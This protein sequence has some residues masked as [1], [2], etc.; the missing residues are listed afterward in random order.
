MKKIDAKTQSLPWWKKPVSSLKGIGPKKAIEFEGL[1][2]V[3]IGDLLNH[4]PR[5]GCYLDY[6][7][8]KTIRE[9]TLDGSMQ[10]FRGQI[11]R[12]IKRRSARN[13]R[14][15]S[16]VVSDGTAFAEIFLFGAQVYAVRYLENGD[17][18]LVIGKVGPGRTAKAVTQAV[19]S[20]VKD[21]HPEAPGILP[22]YAL[23]GSLTQKNVRSAVR[24]ALLLAKHHLP[25]CLPDWI[26]RKKG[27][28]SRYEALEAIHFPP[29]LEKMEEAR[30][31]FIF[32]ELFFIQCGLL[33]HRANIK[34]RSLGIKM[35]HC[36][37][38]WQSVLDHLGF[39]LTESQKKAWQEINDDMESPE[40]M[41]RLLQ[42]DVGSGKT[43]VAMLALAKAAEN[44]Y[45]GCL[46]APT[47]I[48]AEQHYKEMQKVLEPL[49]IH[50]AL[51]TGSLGQAARREVLEGLADGTI[52][53]VVGTYALIQDAVTFHS[54][55][56]AI[57]DE[58]HRFGV[59]QRS[60][61]SGKSSYT[62]H[63]L[64]MTATPIPR[65]LAL[66]VYG[67]LDVSLMKGLPPGRKPIKTLCYTDEKRADVYA[68]LIHQVKEGHQ[69]YIVAPLIEGSDTV[70]AKSATDL[71]EELTQ[72]FLK[73]IPCG[74]LHGRL[75]AEEKDA[76]MADFV[77]GKTKVLIATTVIEVGVNVPN[78]TL[79]IIEG[80]DRFGLAQMHQLRGRVGRG[81]SQSYCVLLTGSNQPQTLERL[82]IMRSCSDGFLLAEKD[83][84]LRGAGQ[85]FGVRQHGLPDLYIADILRDTDTLVEAREYAKRIMADPQG[86]RFIEEGVATTQFDG[87]FEQIFNS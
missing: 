72:T 40:P 42:G 64:V 24:Q 47:E 44:G 79:M 80:A 54:L 36:G 32:E 63:V 39:T 15:A 2:I 60:R 30:R 78:A 6:S 73:G 56:L 65:T 45:Q 49:G 21:E 23:S 43:A 57:T 71:Y 48:L 22:T 26:M 66:T 61:L 25:E 51:L 34:K 58:Q 8:I 68:G 59:E 86:A 75:K 18:V 55:A 53:A 4:F 81:S 10:L 35:G 41:N 9:L 33:H 87:R 5:Q 62:P 77:S 27:F 50:T 83:M 84:E 28:L 13:M 1:G 16:V 74:L 46:M 67:D 12:I 19:I 20:K 31:R 69:A 70:D 14:Y 82:Q 76:V 85:L 3:T 37:P 7:H 11:A 52:K 38:L 17:D 29:S